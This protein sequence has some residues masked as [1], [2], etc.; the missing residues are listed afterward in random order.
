M[1]LFVHKRMDVEQVRLIIVFC[2]KVW[3]CTLC[4]INTS[5]RV[6][7]DSSYTNIS[8]L[9]CACFNKWGLSPG[10]LDPAPFWIFIYQPINKTAPRTLKKAWI[11]N[12]ITHDAINDF[13]LFLD[14]TQRGTALV[15][16]VAISR[17]RGHAQSHV[18]TEKTQEIYWTQVCLSVRSL[19]LPICYTDTGL[20]IC[21]YNGSCYQKKLKQW[22]YMHQWSILLS[23]DPFFTLAR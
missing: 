18:W 22:L 16:Q 11:G 21:N 4:F 19:Q 13:S 2:V 23:H 10:S 12:F 9:L 14:E 6:H 3:V 5:F 20:L 17:Q 15:L 8:N 7:T 1:S